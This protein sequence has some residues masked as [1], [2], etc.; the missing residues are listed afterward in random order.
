MRELYLIVRRNVWWVLTVAMIAGMATFVLLSLR[1]ERYRAESTVIVTPA[2][3]NLQ[4]RQGFTFSPAPPTPF[5][6]YRT[7]A[8]S[9]PVLEA[10]LAELEGELS[11]SELERLVSLERLV[12]PAG[13]QA[14]QA[15]PLVVIHQVTH[16]DPEL[17]ARI[18]NLWAEAALATVRASVTGTLEPVREVTQRELARLRGLLEAAEA[19]LRDFNQQHNLE[20]ARE[21]VTLLSNRVAESELRL[22]DLESALALTR[23]RIATLEAQL[24]G[25]LSSL[26]TL[27]P[28]SSEFLA[29]RTLAEALA[30]AEA[31]V[32]ALQA[33]YAEARQ[34]LDA[35][36]AANDLA[37]L[38]AQIDQLAGRI[39]QLEARLRTLPN[40]IER[41]E[42]RLA[43]LQVQLSGQPPLLELRDQ[44][45]SNPL[46]SELALEDGGLAALLQAG[47]V[48]E[49]LNPR[50]F[51]LLEA[52]LGAELELNALRE[53]AR[54]VQGELRETSALLEEKRAL[55]LQ[56]RTER[57][58]LTQELS[59]AESDLASARGRLSRFE[60]AALDTRE[61]LRL[62]DTT[63]EVVEL[64]RGLQESERRISRLEGERQTTAARL[65]EVRVQLAG[66]REQLVALRSQRELLA[67]RRERA[68]A[69]LRALLEQRDRLQLAAL[70][71]AS[72]RLGLRAATPEVL[73]LRG[74]LREQQLALAA[75][76]RQLAE[77][78][79]SLERDRQTL[80][81]L[82]AELA[83]AELQLARLTRQ[84]DEALEAYQEVARVDP[85]IS[86]FTELSPVSA[87]LLSEATVPVEP[88]GRG[89]L[90][91]TALAVLVTGALLLVLVFLREAIAEPK[92]SDVD[93]R[94]QQ[95]AA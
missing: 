93:S 66:L 86:Y 38:D 29:G 21:R 2:Q 59:Q 61:G 91:V 90:L 27:D 6:T 52:A 10:V 62:R 1:P 50:H 47:L 28:A 13:N 5:E 11:L 20:L 89:R 24:E 7:L 72:E 34:A 39:P 81:G 82:Q 73:E 32:S 78:T 41:V 36:D 22:S 40:E 51:S 60:L 58:R 33:A 63:P 74:A 54:L 8:Q 55:R 31:Q 30:L 64:Q 42:V 84:R 35:F 56:W 70:D 87:R 37:L 69:D 67:L 65:A 68:L 23:T 25:E 45:T 76:E 12:G 88:I 44:L 48:R 53:E 71:P 18:A 75:Q 57:A 46:L 49:V 16:E 19:E 85:T 94:S 80:A 79:R 83:E 9:R 26:T 14:A 77:L 17:A 15:A 95:V 4:D 92:V 43:R 3:L